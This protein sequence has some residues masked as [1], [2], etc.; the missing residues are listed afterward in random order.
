M[1]KK[2][3]I[4]HSFS[5]FGFCWLYWTYTTGMGHFKLFGLGLSWKNIEK[6]PLT[7]SERN[8]YTSFWR[9]GKWVFKFI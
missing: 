8:G 9:K 1:V 5:L 3:F 7:F 2:E 6:V 4:S